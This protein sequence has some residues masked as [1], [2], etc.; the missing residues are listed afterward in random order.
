LQILHLLNMTRTKFR[1][2]H[3]KSFEM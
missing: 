2:L 1:T 3:M